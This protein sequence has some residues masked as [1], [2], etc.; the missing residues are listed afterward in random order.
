MLLSW[1]SFQFSVETAAFSEL[2]ISEEFPWSRVDRIGNTP[3]LQATGKRHRSIS[4]RGCVFPAYRGGADQ[5]DQLAALAGR[6]EPQFLVSGDG[7]NWGQWCLLRIA[8]SDS[9]L[10]PDG[11]PRKQ[12]YT[13]EMERFDAK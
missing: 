8:E 6:M 3:Q 1:G 7:R 4:L 11:S 12:A 9:A 5:V 10:M 13:I 2:E